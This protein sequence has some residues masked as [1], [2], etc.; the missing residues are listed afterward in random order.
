MANSNCCTLLE[1]YLL[2]V[3]GCFGLGFFGVFFFL[4]LG[5]LC[6]WLV[7]FVVF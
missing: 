4:F 2:D 7:G 5:V 1:D 3:M 6:V